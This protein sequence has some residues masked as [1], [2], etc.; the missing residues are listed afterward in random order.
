[1][2]SAPTHAGL[3]FARARKV[4]LETIGAAAD[5]DA[6]NVLPIIREIRKAGARTLREIADVLNAGRAVGAGRTMVCND[7]EQ[8]ARE[9]LKF[10]SRTNWAAG[11]TIHERQIAILR[12]RVGAR[13]RL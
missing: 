9:G 3:A 4:A 10:P 2:V 12:N 7:R 8:R 11:V 6:A 5:P 1:M 13:E